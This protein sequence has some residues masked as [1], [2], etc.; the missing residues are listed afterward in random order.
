GHPAPARAPGRGTRQDLSHLRSPG[1]RIGELSASDPP[2]RVLVTGASGFV[3]SHAA[4]ALAEGGWA[5]RCL[6]RPTS[7]RGWLDRAGCEYAIG[8]V[9]DRSGLDR[10]CQGCEAVVHAAG[11]TNALHPDTYYRIN[12][13]GTLRLWTAAEEAGVRRVLLVSSLAAAGPSPG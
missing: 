3:G 8:D 13:E 11:I 1:P 6:V 10:A 4:E 9:T 12:S 7:S 2:R 5:V